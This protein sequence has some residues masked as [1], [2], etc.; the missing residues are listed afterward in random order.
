MGLPAATISFRLGNPLIAAAGILAA[1]PVYIWWLRARRLSGRLRSI[2]GSPAK[3]GGR[4]LFAARVTAIILLSLAASNP[5]IVEYRSVPVTLSNPEA[6]RGVPV[7][8]IIVV[9]VSKSMNYRDLGES[10]ID[11][12]R[13]LIAKYLRELGAGDNVTIMTFSSNITTLCSGSPEECMKALSR[14]KAGEKYSALGDALA[15]GVLEARVSGIPG[16]VVLVSDGGWN[17]G[18]DPRQVA[19]RYRGTAPVVLVRVGHDPRAT[20]MEEAA[21]IMKARLFDLNEFSLKAIND[22]VSELYMQAKYTALTRAGRTSIRVAYRSYYAS[23]IL[24]V[25]GAFFLI[26]SLREGV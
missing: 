26:A 23:S 25:L 11:A 2:L 8:H 15:R 18:S 9:D 5:Y 22:T 21:A 7:R 14:P 20:V 24:G 19:E 3:P 1:V 17:Y 4:A 16:V 6:Y 12:A 10:R 13:S